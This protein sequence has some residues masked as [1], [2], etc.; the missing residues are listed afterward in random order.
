VLLAPGGTAMFWVTQAG[1]EIAIEVKE[2]REISV[3][4]RTE[5]ELVIS[6]PGADE[7]FWLALPQSMASRLR[8]VKRHLAALQQWPPC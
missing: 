5:N 1:C 2:T 3:P 6:A 4:A 8:A 7:S